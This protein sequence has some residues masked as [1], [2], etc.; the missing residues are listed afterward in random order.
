LTQRDEGAFFAQA[1]KPVRSSRPM[2]SAPYA[3][4]DRFN[5]VRPARVDVVAL[6]ISIPSIAAVGLI[7]IRLDR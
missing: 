1:Q 4:A 6:D 7:R 5:A 3:R 2:S